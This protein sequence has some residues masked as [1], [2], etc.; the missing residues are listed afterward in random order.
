MTRIKRGTN[1]NRRHKK[2]LEASKGYQGRSSTCYRIAKLRVEKAWQ[3]EY[4]DRRNKKRDFRRLWVQRINAATRS[5][6]MNYSR[7]MNCLKKSEIDLNRKMLS[8]IAIAHPTQFKSL[9]D[10][11]ASFA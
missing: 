10:Q 6:G 5:L 8:E 11:V 2:I 9:F 4:R 7:F 3:Y 1:K